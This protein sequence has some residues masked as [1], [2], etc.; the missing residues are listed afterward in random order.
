MGGPQNRYGTGWY[1]GIPMDSILEFQT[2]VD[3]KNYLLSEWPR[4]NDYK[5][6]F[7]PA[8]WLDVPDDWKNPWA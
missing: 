4:R 2:N 1:S 8:F 5:S 7:I 6:C 3:V